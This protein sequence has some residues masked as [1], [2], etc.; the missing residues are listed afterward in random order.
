MVFPVSLIIMF[1]QVFIDYLFI[2]SVFFGQIFFELAHWE[3]SLDVLGLVF[4]ADAS[5]LVVRCLE[6][7]GALRNYY[8]FLFFRRRGQ[9]S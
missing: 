8:F 9:F 7:T 1:V 5:V 3:L 4:V 2:Y 6:T